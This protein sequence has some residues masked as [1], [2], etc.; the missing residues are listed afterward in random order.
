M[1]LSNCVL[2]SQ[3]LQAICQGRHRHQ[4]C[5]LFFFS[6]SRCP[7][8]FAQRFKRSFFFHPRSEQSSSTFSFLFEQI[9][10]KEQNTRKRAREKNNHSSRS[11]S[12]TSNEWKKIFTGT[13]N[14]NCYCC[15]SFDDDETISSRILLE[16][17]I[18]SVIRWPSEFIYL[19]EEISICSWDSVW[20]PVQRDP[21]LAALVMDRAAL[22]SLLIETCQRVLTERHR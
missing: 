17:R 10:E 1:K 21:C 22:F 8:H 9:T 7:S 11:S 3:S 2:H 4:C 19:D 14:V 6:L 20:P 5:F 15:C 18:D 13:S 16:R 12:H